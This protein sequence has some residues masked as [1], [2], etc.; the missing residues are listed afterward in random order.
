MRTHRA[1][2]GQLN[3]P[4]SL[5]EVSHCRHHR[6]GRGHG[7]GAQQRRQQKRVAMTRPLHMDGGPSG[8]LALSHATSF[9]PSPS[10]DSQPSHAR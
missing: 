6:F 9:V 2:L 7:G 5:S 3:R 8:G 1:T 4:E 10:L